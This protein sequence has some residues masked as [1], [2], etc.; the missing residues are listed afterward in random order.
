MEERK[1]RQNHKKVDKNTQIQ[2]ETPPPR[3]ELYKARQKLN[4]TQTEVAEKLGISPKTYGNYEQGH[5]EPGS[6][7]C[8]AL[9]KLFKIPIEQL[10]PDLFYR[11]DNKWNDFYRFQGYNDE[12]IIAA[13]RKHSKYRLFH[14]L[15]R[16]KHAKKDWSQWHD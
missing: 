5:R 8:D 16:P 7:C 13:Q 14:P 1:K 9:E 2:R 15:K 4:M 3:K 12:E 11:F 6:K 10:F